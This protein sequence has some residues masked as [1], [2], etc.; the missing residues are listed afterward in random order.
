[1]VHGQPA[2]ELLVDEPLVAPDPVLDV[3]DE[4][5]DVQGAQVLEEGARDV[6]AAL[7]ASAVRAAAEDLLLGHEDDALGGQDDPARERAD[8]DDGF[9]AARLVEPGGIERAEARLARDALMP[10]KGREAL[11]LRL[12]ARREE[13]LEPVAAPVRDAQREREERAGLALRG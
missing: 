5:T 8:D 9:L 3:D 13:D 11:G 7:L 4:V 10:E 6:L 2:G 1:E 12:R